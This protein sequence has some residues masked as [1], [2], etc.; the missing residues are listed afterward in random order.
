MCIEYQLRPRTGTLSYITNVVL[1]PIIFSVGSAGNVLLMFVF[2]RRSMRRDRAIY[3]YY[4]AVAVVDALA[5][6]CAVPS[7]I[8][9]VELL[10]VSDAYSPSLANI[11]WTC[12]AVQPM[13]RHT[14]AWLTATAAGIRCAV[15]RLGSSTQWTHVGSSRVF[16][17]VVF[18]ACVL[19]D[20]TRFLDSAVVELTDHC[21]AGGSRLWSHNSTAL[22]RRRFY[23][24]LQP[25]VSAVAG[26]TIPLALSLMF[27]LVLLVSHLH[28]CRRDP[29]DLRAPFD[30]DE[31]DYQLSVT[32]FVVSA[33]FFLLD[34]PA[35]AVRLAGVFHFRLAVDTGNEDLNTLTLFVG[36]L[37]LTRCAVNCVI[38]VA[39]NREFRKTTQRELCRCCSSSNGVRFE[40]VTCC[41]P[42]CCP[43]HRRAW[44]DREKRIPWHELDYVA[45]TDVAISRNSRAQNITHLYELEDK[46]HENDRSL[47]I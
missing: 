29:V 36:V 14:A 2:S 42:P 46:R 24:E 5:L 13:L 40:P 9:D 16:M 45:T 21:V 3:V 8:R 11:I 30:N 26:G 35:A 37:S 33:A 34:G 20:F 32:V 12:R 10:P 31:R 17:L 18:V 43:R 25:I 19:L 23:A 15:V 6:I 41:R 27:A 7:F 38:I 1:P 28:C 4:T 47:W 22:G 44:F 39:I